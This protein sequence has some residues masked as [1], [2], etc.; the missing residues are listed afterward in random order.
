MFSFMGFSAFALFSEG[1]RV[2]LVV[3]VLTLEERAQE[4]LG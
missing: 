3:L 1:A 2:A 4:P